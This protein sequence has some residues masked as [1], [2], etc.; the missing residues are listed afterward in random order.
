MDEELSIREPATGGLWGA[1]LAS[2]LN[3]VVAFALGPVFVG[4]GIQRFE[5]T[6]P[7]ILVETLLLGAIAGLLYAFL[8][9]R[10]EDGRKVF[11]GMAAIVALISL[12]APIA[13]AHD[14]ESLVALLLMHFNASV[15][16]T[17][18]VDR[19]WMRR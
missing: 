8:L 11:V 17:L 2:V 15:G 6:V 18:G 7:M 14:R 12:G 16:I 10:M 5:V 13:A 4:Q 9:V 3:T 1:L 19:P